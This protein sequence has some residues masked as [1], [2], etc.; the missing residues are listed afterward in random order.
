MTPQMLVLY[1]DTK[2]EFWTPSDGWCRVRESAAG[3]DYFSPM[4]VSYV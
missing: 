3:L 4:E 2:I 1:R